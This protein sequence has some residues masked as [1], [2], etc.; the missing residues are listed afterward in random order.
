MTPGFSPS[1]VAVARSSPSAV[2]NLPPRALPPTSSSNSGI[3][4]LQVSD[5]SMSLEKSSFPATRTSN[6]TPLSSTPPPDFTSLVLCPHASQTVAIITTSLKCGMFVSFMLVSA[7]A[8]Q[9]GQLVVNLNTSSLDSWSYDAI[10]GSAG[11]SRASE[12]RGS[13]GD[14]VS[15]TSSCENM[16]SAWS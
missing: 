2:V 9:S 14:G 7:T 13:L 4:I 16:P 8:L 6:L 1:C 3:S 12:V 15:V 11:A 10:E 5:F